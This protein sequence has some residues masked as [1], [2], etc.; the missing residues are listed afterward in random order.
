MRHQLRAMTRTWSDR[1]MR[2]ESMLTL[3]SLFPAWLAAS[4]LVVASVVAMLNG[5]A[6]VVFV[7]AVAVPLLLWIS[8]RPQRGLLL[9]VA[10][11]PFDGLRILVPD[12]SVAWKFALLGG[13]L[14]A[15]FVCPSSA[16]GRPYTRLPALV[17]PVAAFL[18]VG[19]VSA[20][21]VGGTQA[22]VGLKLDFAY[23]LAG[24]AVWRC[25]FDRRERDRFV[26]ILMATGFVCAI[27]GVAQ[28]L[29]G[30]AR[31]NA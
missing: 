20:A 13:T 9:L 11:A 22:L 8:E 24:V 16:R 10:L 7:V 4:L 6:L 29:I 18:V 15:T 14:A 30:P 26:S 25:P 19:L 5:H 21:A 17:L 3:R 1:S 27:V 12:V 2:H 28:Q 23:L 31:L